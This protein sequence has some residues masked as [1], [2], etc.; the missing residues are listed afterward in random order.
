[1]AIDEIRFVELLKQCMAGQNEA[2]EHKSA[3]SSS[4]VSGSEL[5]SLIRRADRLARLQ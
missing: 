3:A 2:V 4:A 1:V 5:Y